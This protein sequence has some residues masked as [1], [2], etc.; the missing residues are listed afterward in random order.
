MGD[1]KVSAA[2]AFM[3][4]L[5]TRRLS[6]GDL[7]LMVEGAL[8]VGLLRVRFRNLHGG[9]FFVHR[10]AD[11]EVGPDARVFLGQMVRFMQ[12]FTGHFY[13]DVSIGSNVYFNRGC[14]VAVYDSL[15]IGDDCLFGEY[16]SIHD[17]DYMIDRD[18]RP[19]AERG[20]ATAPIV[21]GSNVLVGAKSTIVRGVRIGDNVVVGANA[22]VT[23]DIPSNSV[24]AG[25]P[26]R[27]IRQT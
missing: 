21:I 23:R 10:R 7:R 1:R 2:A 8:R 19:I 27:V 20:H 18:G 9:L 15:E 16:V 14:Y 26:A 3:R 13:G 4:W 17:Q 6:I 25:I 5:R 11:I 12:D 24:A 22:V